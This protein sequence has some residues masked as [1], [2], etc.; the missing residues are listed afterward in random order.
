MHPHDL[1]LYALKQQY[2]KLSLLHHPDKSNADDSSHFILIKQAYDFAVNHLHT[3]PTYT[4]TPDLDTSCHPSVFEH[5]FMFLQ[6]DGPLLHNISTIVQ[7][8]SPAD[9]FDLTFFVSPIKH[10]LPASLRDLLFDP[11]LTYI[12]ITPTLHNLINHDIY[13]LHHNSS[14][15]YIPTWHHEVYFDHVCVLCKPTLPPHISI[16]CD[17]NLHIRIQVDAQLLLHH[18]SY[19]FFVANKEYFIDSNKI[20]LK[21]KQ[22]VILPHCGIPII[23]P[24]SFYSNISPSHV[25][26]SLTLH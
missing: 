3:Y 12:N 2:Y 16:D 17:N 21:K 14:V 18:S 25:V 19:P 13:V 24:A 7:S 26:I 4:P 15:Y 8:L 5:I 22:Y 9:R 11:H 1:S 10:L 23:S 6:Q 20:F